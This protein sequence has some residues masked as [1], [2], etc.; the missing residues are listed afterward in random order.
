M[1][2]SQSNE[3]LVE[4]TANT[5]LNGWKTNFTNEFRNYC[6]NIENWYV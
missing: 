1:G 3:L 2:Y 6:E 4:Y 5:I